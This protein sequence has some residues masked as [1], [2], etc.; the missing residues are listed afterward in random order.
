MYRNTILPIAC[1]LVLLALTGCSRGP[2]IVPV[3][4]K[5]LYNGQ[6]LTFGSV[7][8]QPEAG[9]PARGVIQ[10]DGTFTLS[11]NQTGDGATVGRNR[12]RVT[13][14]E[15]QN[16]HAASGGRERPLGR[17]LIPPAYN[18][19]DTS[20]IEVQVARGMNVLVTIELID[21][22]VAFQGTAQ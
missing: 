18:D 7:M 14:F 6:P 10:A 3:E 11:T 8:F 2:E 9:Q 21:K 20:G 22:Q 13:C 16:P 1:P 5:V 17:S 19:V 12:V 15:A 4:G